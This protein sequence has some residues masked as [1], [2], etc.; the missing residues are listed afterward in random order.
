MEIKQPEWPSGDQKAW[1]TLFTEGDI[2]DGHGPLSHWR[3]TTRRKC[4]QSYGYWL[5]FLAQEGHLVDTTCPA[6]RTTP[7]AVEAFVETTLCRCSVE[8]THMR[9]AELTKIVRAMSPMTD[10]SWLENA[11]RNLRQRCRHGELKRRAVVTAREL[12]DWGLRR[13][14]AVD[15][16]VTLSV[17]ERAVGYRQ[18]L[19]VALLIAR[20]L[21]LRTFLNL[22]LDHNLVETGG[23]FTLSLAAEDMKDNKARDFPLPP[24]LDRAMARYLSHYRQILLD[25]AQS[26]A[27]WITKDGRAFSSPGF[28]GCLAK[29]TLREFGET[30][31]PH[32][33]RHIAATSV[34]IDDPEHVAIMATIL[35]H[36]T[37][38]TSEAYYNRARSIEAT[39]AYQGVVRDLRKSQARQIRRPGSRRPRL[40]TEQTS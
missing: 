40:N 2:L 13:I 33:F 4:A 9:L 38:N 3:Q 5:A 35:G 6:N 11:E 28:V 17:K 22:R 37:L 29:L 23:Q 1:D 34:A 10:W 25:G 16:D 39:S 12:Y 30:L 18:G 32:A 19:V 15:A 7:E 20:P 21:R 24:G 14:R 31:R 27:L 26:D 36:S 8:T